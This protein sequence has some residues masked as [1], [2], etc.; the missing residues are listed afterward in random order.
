MITI[1]YVEYVDE[2]TIVVPDIMSYLDDV[3]TMLQTAKGD[4]HVQI[5]NECLLYRIRLAIKRGE[6]EMDNI[7]FI[8]RNKQLKHYE[9]GGVTTMAARLRVNR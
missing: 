8:W 6:L 5:C 1:E 4:I 7:I 3:I 2:T 9:N